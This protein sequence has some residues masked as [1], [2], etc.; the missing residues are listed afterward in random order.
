MSNTKNIIGSIILEG[1]TS[2][3]EDTVIVDGGSS[4][5]VI[6]QATLQDMDV[7]NRNHRIYSKRDLS[8]EINGPRMKELLDAGMMIGEMGHPLSNDIVRQQ[9][10]DPKLGCVRFHKIW[11]EGNLVKG[12]YSGTFNDYGETIDQDL[13]AGYKPAFSLRALGSI[14]NV[15]GK[16]YVRGVKVITYDAVIFPSHAKAYTERIVNEN[17]IAD[18]YNSPIGIYTE[19]DLYKYNDTGRIINLTG[20]D[21]QDVLNR[22]QR[23][24]ANMDMI[25][26]TFDR[27]ADKVTVNENNIILSNAFGDRFVVNLE[28]HVE[29]LIMDYTYGL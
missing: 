2:R 27:I 23:E 24:S 25:L 15:N 7:E 28:N 13:R 16:A 10:I 1:D 4:K 18:G 14:E 22:L 29:N 21:A 6:A 17:A 20:S 3:T 26:E 9:T 5:R 8:P 19:N 12:T 11:I